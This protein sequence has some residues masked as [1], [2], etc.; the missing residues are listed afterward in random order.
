MASSL[1]NPCP[2][3]EIVCLYSVTSSRLFRPIVPSLCTAFRKIV[4]YAVRSAPSAFSG[5]VLYTL[6]SV[7]VES[8]LDLIDT[9]SLDRVSLALSTSRYLVSLFTISKPRTYALPAPTVA[10]SLSAASDA[11]I[12]L[13]PTVPSRPAVYKPKFPSL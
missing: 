13:G 3:L 4:G 6:V 8:P 1:S 11:E 7:N 2:L 9:L 5:K 10:I 12:P